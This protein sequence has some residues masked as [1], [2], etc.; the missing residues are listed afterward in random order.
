[1]KAS[2]K[3]HPY[4]VQLRPGFVV[5]FPATMTADEVEVACRDIHAKQKLAS[6]HQ[7]DTKLVARLLNGG[8]RLA[9]DAQRVMDTMPAERREA[10]R[11]AVRS[12]INDKA[13][14]DPVKARKI[15]LSLGKTARAIFGLEYASTKKRLDAE[16]RAAVG[17]QG[18]V[19]FG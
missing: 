3:T 2:N 7:V 19:A 6:G 10:F 14:G 11:D 18:G 5:A 13:A 16:S 12:A 15:F 1:M 17:K 8:S 4:R 9:D